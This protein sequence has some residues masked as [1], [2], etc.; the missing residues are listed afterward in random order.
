[1]PAG[2]NKHT[3]AVVA[4][5][6]GLALLLIRSLPRCVAIVHRLLLQHGPSGSTASLALRSCLCNA[7]RSS[8]YVSTGQ[9]VR[10]VVID[11][12]VTGRF[13]VPVTETSVGTELDVSPAE[14]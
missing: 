9:E 4:L 11:R 13:Q 5:G 2:H 10:R 12:S 1:M 8:G 7:S 14:G 3:A 6:I